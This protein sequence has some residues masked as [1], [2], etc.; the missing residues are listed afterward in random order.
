AKAAPVPLDIIFVIDRSESMCN[1]TVPC[2]SPKWPGITSALTTFFDDPTSA[3]ISAGMT[4]FPPQTVLFASCGEATY[5]ILDVPIAPLPDNAFALKN[6]MPAD[7][8]GDR[9][10]TLAGLKG[11]LLAATAYQDAHPTHKVN[12]VLATDGDPWGC[13]SMN[14][15]CACAG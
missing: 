2:A 5:E 7:A 1:F 8:T 10:P 9:T 4:Y 14:D 11:A 12:V 3:G 6:S 15:V 13:N